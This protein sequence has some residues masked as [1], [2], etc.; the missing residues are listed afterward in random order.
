MFGESN[1]RALLFVAELRDD[2]QRVGDLGILIRGVRARVAQLVLDRL[3]V[4]AV[5]S[6]VRPELV[7]GGLVGDN[8]HRG[9]A[10][11]RGGWRVSARKTDTCGHCVF[12]ANAG[13]A[14]A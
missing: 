4:D 1:V 10:V 9:W 6:G 8:L 11:L 13:G 12:K 7:H 3:A 2:E 14:G 5:E